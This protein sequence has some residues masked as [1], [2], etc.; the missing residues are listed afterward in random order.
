M[1]RHIGQA[2][3]A[4]ISAVISTPSWSTMTIQ[5]QITDIQFTVTD[6]KPNDGQA[7]GFHWVTNPL[8]RNTTDTKAILYKDQS[9]QVVQQ[10]LH[11]VDGNF[12]VVSSQTELNGAKALVSVNGNSIEAFAQSTGRLT[13]SANAFI[14]TDDIGN[15]GMWLAPGTRV[16][17]SANVRFQATN[18]TVCT[19]PDPYNSCRAGSGYV[20]INFQEPGFDYNSLSTMQSFG[21][22]ESTIG[23]WEESRPL[24]LAYENS[25]SQAVFVGFGLTARS[26][27]FAPNVPEPTSWALAAAGLAVAGVAM[28]RRQSAAHAGSSQG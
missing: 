14:G 15:Q 8:S 21:L 3:L 17:F 26:M 2:S 12:A 4:L 22:N 11:K 6:L 27:I 10:D 19:G 5:S 16:T 1:K 24:L 20:F 25:R 13:A 18:D 9:G 23:T 28:R 7:A